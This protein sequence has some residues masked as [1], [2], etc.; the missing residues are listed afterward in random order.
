[1]SPAFW[2][3]TIM[4]GAGLELCWYFLDDPWIFQTT[5]VAAV[6]AVGIIGMIDIYGR[7]D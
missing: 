7:K 2:A 6:I 1:M 5:A 3:I 4:V